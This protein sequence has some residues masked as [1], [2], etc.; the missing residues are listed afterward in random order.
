[1][2]DYTMKCEQPTVKC[3]FIL[4]R[5]EEFELYIDLTLP[6]LDQVQKGH[7]GLVG[8]WDKK[9]PD[10]DKESVYDYE[11]VSKLE[12]EN[13]NPDVKEKWLPLKINQ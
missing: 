10:G 11:A 6:E 8:L 7:W 12:I 9:Y 13:K 3:R 2:T 4:K 5:V 1:M